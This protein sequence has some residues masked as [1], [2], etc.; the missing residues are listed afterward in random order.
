VVAS[1]PTAKYDEVWARASSR[2]EIRRDA[3]R[4]HQEV[5]RAGRRKEG[6]A[7]ALLFAGHENATRQISAFAKALSPRPASSSASCLGIVAGVAMASAGLT[8]T[9]AVAMSV[10][11]FAG[12]AQLAVCRCLSQRRSVGDGRNALVV[13]L[14]YVI[15]SAVSRPTSSICAALARAALVR[16]GGRSVAL[17]AGRYRPD[18]GNPHSTGTIWA[19]RS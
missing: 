1:K 8:Q 6:R 14:R 5:A 11:V 13:N 19:D 7:A 15:Y 10:L 12:T 3:L 16:H 2:R 18:D 17:F 4:E 9:Q